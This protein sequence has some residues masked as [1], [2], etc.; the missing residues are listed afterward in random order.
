MCGWRRF[1]FYDCVTSYG[2]RIRLAK[3]SLCLN[4]AGIVL[5]LQPEPTKASEKETAQT[6]VVTGSYRFAWVRV[7]FDLALITQCRETE[8]LGSKPLFE[9]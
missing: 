1:G 2:V 3:G 9:D 8:T 4:C 7:A 5:E 6:R